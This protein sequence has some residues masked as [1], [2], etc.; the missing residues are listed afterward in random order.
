M[1]RSVDNIQEQVKQFTDKVNESL[2]MAK[3]LIDQRMKDFDGDVPDDIKAK[4][5]DL[6]QKMRDYGNKN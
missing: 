1:S 3:V 6:K 2:E 5:D 4:V